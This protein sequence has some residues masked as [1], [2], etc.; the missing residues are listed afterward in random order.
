MV[1]P[2]SIKKPPRRIVSGRLFC[3][4][5]AQSKMMPWAGFATTPV[6][7]APLSLALGLGEVAVARHLEER[8][9]GFVTQCLAR[10]LS[11]SIGPRWV[12]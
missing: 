9:A 11:R 3:C 8:G 6:S 7:F 1:L 10:S 4:L 5:I 12:A 2:R